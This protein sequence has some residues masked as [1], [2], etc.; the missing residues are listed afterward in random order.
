M[1]GLPKLIVGVTVVAVDGTQC[2]HVL[3][4]ARHE[5]FGH[6]NEDIKSLERHDSAVLVAEVQQPV[7]E[8]PV[9]VGIYQ[10]KILRV[11]W[12]LIETQ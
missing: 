3:P 8:P 7:D 4:Q 12:M 2:T 1:L 5:Y 11:L 9:T 6:L 10:V